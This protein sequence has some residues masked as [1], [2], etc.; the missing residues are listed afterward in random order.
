MI[1][2]GADEAQKLHMRTTYN[3]TNDEVAKLRTDPQQVGAGTSGV[4]ALAR[5][6]VAAD[7]YGY[8]VLCSVQVL[9]GVRG[10][11]TC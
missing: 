9:S 5:R 8:S 3:T 10:A 6:R 11:C 1:M 7:G 2:Q 4:G